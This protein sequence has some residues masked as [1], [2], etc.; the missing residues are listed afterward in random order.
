MLLTKGANKTAAD[1]FDK[2]PLIWASFKGHVDV[3][4]VLLKHEVDLNQLDNMNRTALQFAKSEGHDE[5][6]KLLEEEPARRLAEVQRQVNAEKLV[7]VLNIAAPVAVVL[8]GGA[9]IW[10][11]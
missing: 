2:T 5:I 4:K 9:A 1:K 7:E 3:V 8:I 6:V 11:F 10:W